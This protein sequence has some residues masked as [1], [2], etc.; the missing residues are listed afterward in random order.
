MTAAAGIVDRDGVKALGLATAAAALG[1]RSPSLST[2]VAGIAGLRRAVQLHAAAALND[3]FE[4]AVAG[5]SGRLALEAI[6]HA[7][8]RFGHEHPGLLEA[9]L[10]A[11]VPGEDD[12][13]HR[14]RQSGRFPCARYLLAFRSPYRV[15]AS[16]TSLPRYSHGSGSHPVGP[17]LRPILDPTGE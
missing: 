1:V 3:T 17:P 6:A 16:E 2:H 8:R 10:P 15:E 5:R 13:V 14:P 12:E 7:H 11:P 4:G 9:L